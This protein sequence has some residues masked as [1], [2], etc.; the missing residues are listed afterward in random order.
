[1]KFFTTPNTT[2][3][4][5]SLFLLSARAPAQD[6]PYEDAA[7]VTK[8]GANSKSDLPV[9]SPE[10]L[11]KAGRFQ[12]RK[13]IFR[14]ALKGGGN[15]A[16]SSADTTSVTG[17]GAEGRLAFGWDMAF[18]PIYL[19]TEFGYRGVD[20][21]TTS[22]VHVILVQQGLY[23]RERL[24]KTSMWKPGLL[25][26]LDV[27]FYDSEFGNGKVT[28]VLPSLGLTSLWEFGPVLF[29]VTGYLHKIGS[30]A[31]FLSASVLGG[32]KF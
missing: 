21:T 25:T 26:C 2:L 18:Q 31:K 32:I 8:D 3:L 16:Y 22:P 15:F 7:P 10:E 13:S 9:E 20:L 11:E 5:L 30:D 6:Y 12:K 4:F 17:F 28:G 29:Q 24:G 19:E 14:M 27:R 23:Y 1:M